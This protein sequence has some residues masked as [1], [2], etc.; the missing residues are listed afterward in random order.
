MN[1]LIQEL[2]P[3]YFLRDFGP[4]DA[5]LFDAAV[6]EDWQ[7]ITGG[8]TDDNSL[9]TIFLCLAADTA[10]QTG[11]DSKDAAARSPDPQAAC[12]DGFSEACPCSSSSEA[13]APYEMQ[14]DLAALWQDF[15]P[16][17]ESVS[18]RCH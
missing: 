17:A 1:R 15:A 6:S 12:S 10:A 13:F 18:A 4:E 8:K 16:E 5:S 9:L 3:L 11:A 14:D 2:E 7:R